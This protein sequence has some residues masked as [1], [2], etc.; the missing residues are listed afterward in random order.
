MKLHV[1]RIQDVVRRMV[2]DIGTYWAPASADGHAAAEVAVLEQLVATGGFGPAEAKKHLV[3]IIVASTALANAYGVSLQQAFNDASVPADLTE[4]SLWPEQPVAPA[5]TAVRVAEAFAPVRATMAFYRSDARQGSD[6]DVVALRHSIP[7]L[8]RAAFTGFDSAD[9]LSGQLLRHFDALRKPAVPVA[10]AEF[11]PSQAESVGLIRPIQ[12][13]TVCPFAL[14]STLWGS[15]SYDESLSFED[16]MRRSLPSVRQFIR[17]LDRDVVDGYVYAFPTRIFGDSFEDLQ[18][19]FRNFV[20]FLHRTMTDAA[21]A[22]LDPAVATDPK[23]FLV[24]ESE[25]CFISV[26][27]PC[28][29]HD[30]SRYMNGV[31]GHF[32]FMLQ[33]EAAVLRQLTKNDYHQRSEAIRF[34]FRDGFQAYTLADIEVDRFLLPMRPDQP[35]VKWYELNVTS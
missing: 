7:H 32:L 20:D 10:S 4:A 21:P 31:E 9:D 33:P 29:P 8:L 18:Q 35:P 1:T 15:P 3:E 34:R 30:H 6:P 27:A 23:W 17:I 2:Q 19:L 22:G 13:E 5:E 14:K 25:E 24:L 28:Y 16:N 26:F 11:D 12:T